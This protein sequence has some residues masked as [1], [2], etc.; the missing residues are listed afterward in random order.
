MTREKLFKMAS[1]PPYSIAP[2][3]LNELLN[4]IYE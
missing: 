2:E 1:A 3:L 4:E